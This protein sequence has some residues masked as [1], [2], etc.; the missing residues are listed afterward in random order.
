MTRLVALLGCPNTGKSTVFNQ[1]TGLRQKTGNYPGVTV[2]RITGRARLGGLEADLIDLPGAYS[3]AA[4]GPETGVTLDTI[5]GAAPGLR[6]PDA[7]LVVADASN[8]RRSLHLFSQSRELGLAMVVA[9]NMQ[10][11][12]ER[13]GV[14]ID[15][16]RLARE[17]GAPVIPIT[18]SRGK[19]I[20]RLR[21]ALE[22]ALSQPAE[23]PPPMMPEVRKAARELH[24]RPDLSGMAL[25]ALE[26]A[27]IDRAGEFE[28]RL[29]TQAGEA[30]REALTKARAHTRRLCRTESLQACEAQ[31]RYRQVDEWLNAAVIEERKAPGPREGVFERA[32]SHPVLGLL[33][34]VGVMGSVFQAVFAWAAPLMDAISVLFETSGAYA[35]SVLPPGALASLLVDGL[36]AGVGAVMVFLPQIVFLF[37]LVLFL[38]DCGYMAR[39]SFLMDRLLRLCGLSGQSFIPLLSGFACAVPAIMSARVIG[40]R[41]SRLATIAAIPLMTCSARLP[42][43]ALLISGFVP[44]AHYLNGWINLHGLLLLGL[45]L[46][47]IGGGALSA[48]IARRTALRGQGASFLMKCRRSAGPTCGFWD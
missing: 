1:L 30:A 42:V 2:E 29:L 38:E 11:V 36:W 41:R 22:R 44:S 35:L 45:Y 26:R 7:L 31:R 32:V 12:A 43:Y 9:L 23:A 8:L 47:G 34:F 33:I 17:I 20:G 28:R 18:A 19:G 39:A 25:P 16:K 46:L 3:L 48:M 21:A 40:D 37:A 27:V 4:D 5:L 24:E 10:D 15:T 14:T 6:H 13:D